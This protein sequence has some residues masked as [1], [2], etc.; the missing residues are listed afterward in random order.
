MKFLFLIFFSVCFLFSIDAQTK[1]KQITQLKRERDSLL[2]LQGD[3][4]IPQQIVVDSL[5]GCILA[6]NLLIAD[7]RQQIRGLEVSSHVGTF[8]SPYNLDVVTFR[9][10]DTIMQAQSDE[11]WE[12]AGFSEQPAW[13]YYTKSDGSIDSSA[14]KLYNKFAIA[15]SRGLA[16]YGW[17]ISSS[18]NWI[19]LQ[20]NLLR[21]DYHFSDLIDSSTNRGLSNLNLNF[22]LNGWRDVGFGGWG[23]NVTFWIEPADRYGSLEVIPTV[24]L[25]SESLSSDSFAYL[26]NYDSDIFTFGGTSWIMG[27]YVRCVLE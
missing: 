9:N 3:L 15:D 21:S 13:C 2:H 19:D 7:L 26:R 22:Y 16:P 14:G 23:D 5:Q 4:G 10:G 17:R 27:H 1:A 25:S 6:K 12:K 20:T 8:W 18:T 11:S 24:S